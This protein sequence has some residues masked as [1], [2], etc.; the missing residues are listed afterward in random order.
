MS[1]RDGQTITL[2]GAGKNAG[3]FTSQATRDDAQR[4]KVVMLPRDQ[5]DPLEGHPFQVREDAAMLT[6]T[7]S[8][9]ANGVLNPVLVRPKENGRYEFVGGHRRD[10]ACGL[11]GLS[12][13]PAIIRDMSRDESVIFMVESNF[14][15]ETILSS[16]K[17]FAY[18]MRLDAMK[19]QAG[20]PSKEKPRPVGENYSVEQLG[21]IS[22]ESG[23]QIHRYIRLTALVPPLLQLVDENKI[24]FR[25]AVELSY[26]RKEEQAAL[27]DS[28]EAEAATPSLAQAL[29]MKKFSQEGKL[30]EEV[31]L[32]IMQEE[33]PNQVEQFK[34]PKA[35][36][37]QYF[38]PGTPAKDIEDRI[39]KALDLLQRRER[40]QREKGR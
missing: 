22:G 23:R 40:Q 36:L 4:E 6:L 35:K 33:K 39:I 12:E 17:A 34:M 25:P 38:K 26:L 9:K 31:I 29:K 11:A 19:R 37:S 18:K 14:Q 2:P 27:L 20:R 10:Y 5:I 32:S 8:V 13:I 1:A 16:E 3:L 24:A 15:R 28:I 21:E 30:N 7:E